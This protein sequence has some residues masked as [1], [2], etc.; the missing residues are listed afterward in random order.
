MEAALA[1]VS[2]PI[3]F[4]IFDTPKALPCTHAYCEACLDSCFSSVGHQDDLQCPTCP[5]DCSEVI[6]RRKVSTSVEALPNSRLLNQLIDEYKESIGITNLFAKFVYSYIIHSVM[7]QH[8]NHSANPSC[9]V[10]EDARALIVCQECGQDL[11]EFHM[12]AHRKTKSTKGHTLVSIENSESVKRS[13]AKEMCKKHPEERLALF[14]ERCDEV[15]CRD[16]TSDAHRG[17]VCKPFNEVI[18]AQKAIVLPLRMELKLQH[19]TLEELVK[20]IKE[21]QEDVKEVAATAERSLN[22]YFRKLTEAVESRR[23]EAMVELAEKLGT[24]LKVLS[25]QED[26]LNK[27]ITTSAMKNKKMKT[28]LKLLQSKKLLL[29]HQVELNSVEDKPCADTDIYANTKSLAWDSAALAKEFSMYPRQ[30]FLPPKKP[31]PQPVKV[32]NQEA[33][34]ALE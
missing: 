26:H 10:C 21:R 14:C 28:D 34:R 12:Q 32:A 19:D 31:A 22:E 23:A 3:C 24:R 16:C 6:D 13:K 4:E 2:C 17:H 29:N 25:E 7:Q 27:L 33:G 15:V 20:D 1:R 9:P 30:F 11:C 5:E 18:E 8:A